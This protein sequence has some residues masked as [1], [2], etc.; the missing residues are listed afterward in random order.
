[1]NSKWPK[2]MLMSA[3]T[4]LWLLYDITT[5]AEAP[6]LALALLQYSLL[7]CGLFALVGSAVMY[8]TDR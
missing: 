6:R 3:A 4:S 2:V 8:A 5:A 7:A 1:M